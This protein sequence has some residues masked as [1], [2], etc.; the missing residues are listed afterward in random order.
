MGEAAGFI[1]PGGNG[2]A[3]RC[4]RG[5]LRMNIFEE[6]RDDVVAITDDFFELGGAWWGREGLAKVGLAD[7]GRDRLAPIVFHGVGYF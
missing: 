6:S 3:K 4:T 7:N 1:A 2:N 5:K